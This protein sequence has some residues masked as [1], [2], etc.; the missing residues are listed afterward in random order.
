MKLEDLKHKISTLKGKEIDIELQRTLLDEIDEELCLLL[1][2]RAEITLRIALHKAT[3]KIS[4]EDLKR[5][6]E[7]NERLKTLASRYKLDEDF[8]INLWKHL[9]TQVKKQQSEIAEELGLK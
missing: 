1:A 7:Q 9:R 5:E 6:N 4:A 8:V 3:H 2:E